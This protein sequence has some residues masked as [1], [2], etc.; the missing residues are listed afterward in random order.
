[1]AKGSRRKVERTR[2]VEWDGD[3]YVLPV[4]GK[5]RDISEAGKIKIA[6][7]VCKMYSTDR[8]PLRECLTMA[9]IKSEATWY[10]WCER[11]KEIDDLFIN[12]QKS[13]DLK[14][15]ARVRER[16][17]TMF[18][19]ALSGYTVDV[20]RNEYEKVPVYDE[21]GKKI[22]EKLKKTKNT[23]HQIY[24]RPQFAAILKAMENNT[25]FNQMGTNIPDGK[26][27]MDALSDQE[28]Q[29]R[30]DQLLSETEKLDS[31]GED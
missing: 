21:N 8:Y 30:Y 7:L 26:S 23:K 13:K 5:G 12:S 6:E 25:F 20:E 1:M 3:K 24:I 2:S 16:A 19:R 4:I 27:G 10:T 14:Y 31:D 22:G 28:L 15:R 11:I 29:D 18:E 9:G 17:L